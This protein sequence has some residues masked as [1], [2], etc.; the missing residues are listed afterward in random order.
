MQLKKLGGSKKPY[1]APT[2]VVHG[3]VKDLTQKV[4]VHGS[5]DNGTNFRVKTEIYFFFGWW[6]RPRPPILSQQCKTTFS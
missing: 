4:G 3:T 2:L 5:S 6:A 1:K